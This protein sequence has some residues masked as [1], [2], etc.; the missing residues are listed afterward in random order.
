MARRRVKATKRAVLVL[1]YM[2]FTMAMLAL[3]FSL[4]EFV[5]RGDTTFLS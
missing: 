2:V 1:G 3:F 5:S 4:M